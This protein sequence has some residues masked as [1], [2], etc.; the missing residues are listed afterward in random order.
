M[1]SVSLDYLFSK[2]E[3]DSDLLSLHIAISAA[4]VRNQP[5]RQRRRKMY[6]S[7]CS[8]LSM[9]LIT[10]S[11]LARPMYLNGNLD[12]T[13][14]L[15]T[16][17][18]GIITTS[19]LDKIEP[20]ELT[21]ALPSGITTNNEV[22]R[23]TGETHT[24]SG[25]LG[26]QATALFEHSSQ[27]NKPF[28]ITPDFIMWLHHLQDLGS[29]N[30]PNHGVP[31]Y[32]LPTF[33]G[34]RSNVIQG[35]QTHDSSVGNL[36]NVMKDQRHSI[37]EPASFENRPISRVPEVTEDSRKYN[38]GNNKGLPSKGKEKVVISPD[39]RKI[40][41]RIRESMVKL[42]ELGTKELEAEAGIQ[43]EM[44]KLFSDLKAKLNQR[45]KED[46]STGMKLHVRRA[47]DRAQKKL[48]T[49]FLGFLIKNHSHAGGKGDREVLISGWEYLKSYMLNWQDANLEVVLNLKD[50]RVDDRVREWTPDK[51]LAYLMWMNRRHALPSKV[52]Y[53]FV[54]GWKN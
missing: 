26:P 17:T 50:L 40:Y 10:I 15:G 24:L 41:T 6:S 1:S 31:I 13:L 43:G 25:T 7:L 28:S 27:Q 12:T 32:S 45:M 16:S 53:K 38:I 46:G 49:T 52:L 18:P 51:V 48:I 34:S 36:A 8:T 33:D 3:H 20:L 22:A 29:R 39:G 21:L 5:I 37:I 2:F 47:F 19:K 30:L 11:V 23:E 9:T 44:V 35:F 42:S 4:L 14:R 54:S